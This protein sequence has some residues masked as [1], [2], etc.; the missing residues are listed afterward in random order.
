MIE[1]NLTIFGSVY[2]IVFPDCVPYAHE[3]RPNASS[4]DVRPT[5]HL[6]IKGG[7]QG[8]VWYALWRDAGGRH[9]KRLGPAHVRDSGRRTPRGAVVWW[10]A[11]G[12]KPD[13]TYLTPAERRRRS[14]S[15]SGPPCGSPPTR[16][17]SVP[18]TT[19]S[20][21]HARRGSPT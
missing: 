19:R 1:P 5:G 15:C 13:P 12:S 8:R 11:N 6:Q 14:R 9:R 3:M 7:P 4:D 10:A 17:A 20:V 16:G 21:R 18:T 2:C